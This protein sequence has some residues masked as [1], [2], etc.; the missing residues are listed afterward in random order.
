MVARQHT[1]PGTPRGKGAVAGSSGHSGFHSA[2][3]TR[4]ARIVGIGTAA[5][6]K[7]SLRSK[8]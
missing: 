7:R 2:V 4:R 6:L 1:V 5:E 3:Y 8:R